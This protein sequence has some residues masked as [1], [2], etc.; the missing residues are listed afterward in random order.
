M[1]VPSN[2]SYCMFLLFGIEFYMEK[3]HVVLNLQLKYVIADMVDAIKEHFYVVLLADR[4]KE[5][6]NGKADD[7]VATRTKHHLR[8]V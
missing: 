1:L 5:L 3:E 6:S 7:S 4:S 2:S 8:L